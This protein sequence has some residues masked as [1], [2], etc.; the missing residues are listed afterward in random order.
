MTRRPASGGGG[1]KASSSSE[2]V[3]AAAGLTRAMRA[4][5]R[6]RQ[7]DLLDDRATVTGHGMTTKALRERGVIAGAMPHAVLTQ[8]G[9]A[10]LDAANCDRDEPA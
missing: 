9:R 7:E 5:L 1:V 10:V 4:A 6:R 8:F 3:K 2:P